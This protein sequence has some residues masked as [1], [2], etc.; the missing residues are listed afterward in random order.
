MFISVSQK[1]PGLFTDHLPEVVDQSRELQH[2]PKVDQPFKPIGGVER[3]DSTARSGH[4]LLDLRMGTWGYDKITAI[5]CKPE[6]SD[7]PN[8]CR[9]SGVME[10]KMMVWDVKWREYHGYSPQQQLHGR[11]HD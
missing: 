9:T 1:L 5:L 4:E 6:R 7:Y 10:G 11:L 2:I 8:G 3:G